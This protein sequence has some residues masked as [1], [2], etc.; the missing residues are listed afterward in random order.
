MERVDIGL[1]YHRP[2][3]TGQV[4]ERRQVMKDNKKSVELERALRRRT[5]KLPIREQHL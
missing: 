4:K 2:S 3:R 5:C 1:P